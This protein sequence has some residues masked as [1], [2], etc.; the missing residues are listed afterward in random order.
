MNSLITARLFTPA[1]LVLHPL[2]HFLIHGVEIAKHGFA[3]TN[4]G[5]CRTKSIASIKK[6][7]FKTGETTGE[8]QK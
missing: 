1:V 8:S 5:S 4:G 7:K 6:D 3:R 2:D